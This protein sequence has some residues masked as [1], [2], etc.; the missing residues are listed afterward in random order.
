MDRQLNQSAYILEKNCTTNLSIPFLQCL[1]SSSVS[2]SISRSTLTIWF[3]VFF[4]VCAFG[5]VNNSILFVVIAG[6]RKL[7]AGSGLLIL[8]LIATC[9]L[10]CGIHYPILAVFVYGQNFW[11]ILPKNIC[12]FIHFLLVT[13]TYAFFWTNCWLAVNR[14]I[15]ILFPHKYVTW[16]TRKVSA[17]MI[18]SSWVVGAA[19]ILPACFGIGGRLVLSTSGQCTYLPTSAV[20]NW[21]IG[22]NAYTSYAVEGLACILILGKICLKRLAVR[23]ARVENGLAQT[24]IT[25]EAVKKRLAF[26]RQLNFAGTLMLS[27]LFCALCN[28]P[29]S[30]ASTFFFQYSSLV[31]SLL[32]WLRILVACQFAF[33]PVSIL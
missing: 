1:N 11:F 10:M 20:G 12:N 30:V 32:L 18:V 22:I 26:R 28:L 7:R 24:P 29:R 13:T 14:V 21:L 6:S 19:G 33:V 16:T 3:I 5:M 27:V 2:A 31:P 9:F 4:T 25:K 15:A 8:H 23:S 17:F